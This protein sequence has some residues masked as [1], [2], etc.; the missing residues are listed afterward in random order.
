MKMWPYQR[1]ELIVVMGRIRYVCLRHW[2]STNIHERR[3]TRYSDT[4]QL[5]AILQHVYRHE[6]LQSLHLRARHAAIAQH[7]PK[8]ALIHEQK[9]ATFD[10]QDVP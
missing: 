6:H 10:D 7:S 8:S 9:Q 1:P 3:P 4:T 2:R 5:Y